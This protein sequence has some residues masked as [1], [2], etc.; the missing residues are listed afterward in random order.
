M[1]DE[2]DQEG[3]QQRFE[4]FVG[5]LPN[6]FD[7]REVSVTNEQPNAEGMV[8]FIETNESQQFVHEQVANCLTSLRLLAEPL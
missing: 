4:Q 3:I 6:H 1:F 5:E 8:V 2:L 7:G